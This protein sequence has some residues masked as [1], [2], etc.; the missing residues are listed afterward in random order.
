MLRIASLGEWSIAYYE[1]T[2]V[3]GDEYG[4]GLSEYYSE[5]DTRAPAVFVMGDREFAKETMGVEHGQ[6][7]SQEQ[8]TAWFNEAISPAGPGVGK[9]RGGLAGHDLLV[10]VPKSLSA[11]AAL[12]DAETAA[13]IVSII[14]RAGEMGLQYLHKHAGYTRVTNKLDPQRKDL[15][16]LPAMPV[17]A[18]YHHTARPARPD[19]AHPDFTECDPHEHIHFL[20]PGRIARKDGRFVS[21]DTKSMYHEAKAAGMIV[22]KALRDLSQS[23]LGLSWGDVDRNTG[24]AELVGFDRDT[25]KAWSRRRTSLLDW[26]AEHPSSGADRLED[27]LAE[28]NDDETALF[29]AAKSI[30]STNQKRL[31]FAQ[32][33]TRQKKG[34]ALHYDELRAEWQADPRAEGIDTKAML[35]QYD[36][37]D[38]KQSWDND[39]A[40]VVYAHLGETT[41]AWT[42]ADLVE[43]T[44]AYWRSFDGDRV[45]TLDDIENEVDRLITEGGYQVTENREP[46]EREGKVRYADAM[47]LER[48]TRLIDLVKVQH[49]SMAIPVTEDW[50]TERGCTPQQARVMTELATSRRLI[51]VLQGPAGSRKTTTLKAL[52]ERAE[53]QGKK[54]VLVST[55][56]TAVNEAKR[57]GASTEA[58]TIASARLAKLMGTLNWDKNTVLVMDEAGMTGNTA[59]HD[60]IEAAAEAQAKVI[61]IGDSQQL[62]PVRA[63]G[64]LFSRLFE[65]LPWSQSFGE[66]FRQ[67]DPEERTMSLLMRNA[68]TMKTVNEVADW[69]SAHDRIR[70]G[71]EWSMADSLI[72]EYFDAVLEDHD[73]MAFADTWL[74]ADPLNL[75]IQ[76]IFAVANKTEQAPVIAIGHDA[77]ARVGDLVMTTKNDY[78]QVVTDANGRTGYDVDGVS[79]KDRWLVTGINNDGSMH[80]RR[81]HDNATAHLNTEYTQESV[82]L[83]YVGTFHAA[84]GA[85]VHT[86][87]AIGSADTLSRHALYPGMT[88]GTHQN[89]VFIT[90]KIAGYDEHHVGQ[91]E[92]IEFTP[93]VYSS[94]KARELFADAV[95]RRGTDI[96]AL[97]HAEQALRDMLLAGR[98]P[99]LYKDDFR[100]VDPYVA[101]T[102]FAWNDTLRDLSTQYAD[103][104]AERGELAQEHA[105]EQA[106]YKRASEIQR[107]RDRNAEYDIT[108]EDADDGGAI[109]DGGHRSRDEDDNT[110]EL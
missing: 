35:D 64:G 67:V 66:V 61:L 87:L 54:I 101:Q 53:S 106:K 88:R 62:Q 25:V 1:S 11:Y 48:E 7:I 74:I 38:H 84:Q 82:V 71:D 10:S 102:V 13:K 9:T 15:E 27:L 44:V 42:R 68:N 99:E 24:I 108:Y 26:A 32:K 50:F 2:A 31:D 63:G 56:K 40:D 41:A 91:S 81:L 105:R 29:R 76:R 43:A 109:Q 12:S 20:L 45:S 22:Q 65:Q 72:R 39:L 58:R 8:V 94:E 86:G 19:P 3:R 103:E 33:D 95:A 83:G 5:R 4:G 6:G 78:D 70:A 16:H 36:P 47:T 23:E 55:A 37:D 51:N 93:E 34:E 59:L 97:E 18:Y 92:T 57:A 77:F 90:E 85:T 89:L 107:D 30:K 14:T 98:D 46:W 104:L 79:N 75:R 100:G 110:P 69:Y 96:T 49:R 21:I 80:V 60:I 28:V 73:V 17:V 52:R